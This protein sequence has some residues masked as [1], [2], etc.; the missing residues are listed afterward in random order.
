MFLPVIGRN[1]EGVLAFSHQNELF[2]MTVGVKRVC[3]VVHI[4]ILPSKIEALDRWAESHSIQALNF[5]KRKTA[6]PRNIAKKRLL[7]PV[8]LPCGFADCNPLKPLVRPLLPP[9]IDCIGSP[10]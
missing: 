3:E 9:R 7:L 10:Q 8:T 4:V 2:G 5:G 6:S 1:P